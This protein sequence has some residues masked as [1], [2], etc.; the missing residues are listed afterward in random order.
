MIWF[1][2]IYLIGVLIVF[3]RL[4]KEGFKWQEIITLADVFCCLIVSLGSWPL[5]FLALSENLADIVIW[6][7]KKDK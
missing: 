3:V 2:S 5:I 1:W 6:R 4:I 7:K